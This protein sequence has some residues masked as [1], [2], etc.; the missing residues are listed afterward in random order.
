MTCAGDVCTR[1]LEEAG[2]AIVPGEAFGDPRFARMST[3]EADLP[4]IQLAPATAR[5]V[6]I[7]LRRP[8]KYVLR[9]N[10]P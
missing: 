5:A 4:R 8:A 7:L 3:A 1:I 2:V 6:Q 9:N 10:G